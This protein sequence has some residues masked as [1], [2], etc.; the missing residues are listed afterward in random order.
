MG[1]DMMGLLS[2][3]SVKEE[4]LDEEDYRVAQKDRQKKD[5][6]NMSQCLPS[7]KSYEQSRVEVGTN[8]LGW[9]FVELWKI[10]YWIR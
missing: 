8:Q 10:I 9:Q 6:H 3:T 1:G 7:Y 5:N 4:P 2:Q